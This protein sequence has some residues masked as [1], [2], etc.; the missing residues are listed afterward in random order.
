M[1]PGPTRRRFTRR[2]AVALAALGTWSVSR[3]APAQTVGAA[4]WPARPVRLIVVYPVGGVSDLIARALAQRMAARLGVAVV[5]DNRAGAGGSTGLA[6]LAAAAPDG[7]TLAFSAITPLS[8]MP[9]LSRPAQ[10]LA[11]HIEP[12]VAVA[13][14][15]ALLVA[16]SAF[17]GQSFADLRKTARSSGEPLR[18][19]TTG[20]GTT[21]HMLLEQV[22]LATGAPITH[23]PYKGGSNQINDALAGHFELLST[24]VG[25]A[26]LAHV[27]A[28]RLRPLAVGAPARLDTLPQVPTFDELGLPQ[29]N[30]ASLFGLFV[31]AG[32]PGA[33]TAALNRLV[34]DLLG[35]QDMRAL[36][37][38][39]DNLPVGGS[40]A[41]FARRIDED[42]EANRRLV[43]TARI[44][45][46][47]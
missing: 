31:P 36:L 14:I 18:W 12:L 39:N 2:L 32:T 45:L 9:H 25:P 1:P 20:V 27:R 46:G 41:A 24:N 21:G 8:L 30:L 47:D 13:S 34:N 38:A 15:P 11:R 42:S 28:G 23:I 26:Q 4:P 19:A 6:A 29:A 7:H 35:Q 37:M 16:T 5:V 43:Q 22:R 44:R 40:A 17:E 10:Q 33:I 3:H